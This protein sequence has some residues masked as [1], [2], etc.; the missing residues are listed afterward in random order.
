MATYTTTTAGASSIAPPATRDFDGYGF[1]HDLDD[2]TAVEPLESPFNVAL[3]PPNFVTDDAPGQDL[4]MASAMM[5]PDRFNKQDDSQGFFVVR[6]KTITLSKLERW[7]TE[8]RA[9]NAIAL[10]DGRKEISFEGIHT[11]SADDRGLSWTMDR[12]F[13]DL[14]VCVGKGLGLGPVIPNLNVHHG[15]IFKLDLSKPYRHFTAKNVK[16]GFDPTGSMLWIGRSPS[17]EDVWLAFVTRESQED[18]DD[19][20]IRATR[21]RRFQGTGRTTSSVLNVLQQ[22]R[23]IMFLAKAIQNTQHLD[24]VVDEEYPNVE[25]DADYRFATNVL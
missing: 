3:L 11:V 19:E 5:A 4:A 1:T 10:L 24:I 13:L 6:P 25:D 17:G 20:D 9:G 15:F 22:R 12:S 14:M 7:Y 23:V 18:S 21:S 2:P 8:G 16:L